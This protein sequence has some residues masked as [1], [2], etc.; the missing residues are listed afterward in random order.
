MGSGTALI[1]RDERGRY[2]DVLRLGPGAAT[3]A[4]RRSL[5]SLRLRPGFYFQPEGDGAGVLGLA[6]Y[7]PDRPGHE[8]LQLG[9]ASILFLRSQG[10]RLNELGELAPGDPTGDDG[11]VVSCGMWYGN[12]RPLFLRGRILAL[13]GYE[14]VEGREEDG[15]IRELRRV[16]LGPTRH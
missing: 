1:G 10:D 16:V 7:G 5:D 8:F 14:L 11:C 13:L 6:L 3:L 12:A 9:S 15:R 4:A 2:L